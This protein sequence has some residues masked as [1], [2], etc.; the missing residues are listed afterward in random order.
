MSSSLSPAVV[1]FAAVLVVLA[2]VA[3]GSVTTGL[4]A[5]RENLD[6]AVG[7]SGVAPVET[8]AVELT[9]SGNPAWQDAIRVVHEGDDVA[10]VSIVTDTGGV[11]EF[12]VSRVVDSPATVM[13]RLDAL[14][15]VGMDIS[16]FQLLVDGQQSPYQSVDS[17]GYT[18]VSFHMASFS[19][20]AVGFATVPPAPDNET[21]GDS[22]DGTGSGD[23]GNSTVDD[24]SNDNGSIGDNSTVDDSSESN[25]SVDDNSTVDDS[26]NDNGSIGD[27]STVD[28]SS[29]DNGSI[30]DN[31]TV[32]DSSDDNVT[33]DGSSPADDGNST[34]DDSNS[35]GGTAGDAGDNST[36]DGGDTSV[37]DSGDDGT[38]GEPTRE[39]V[40]DA[41]DDGSVGDGTDDSSDDS[42][43]DDS[44]DGTGDGTADSSTDEPAQPAA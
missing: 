44:T 18:W 22:D 38:A 11:V 12:T 15:A 32:D 29:N 37:D 3:G 20:H 42:T 36:D 8:G 21:V 1:A 39:P 41:G 27:N 5:D 25:A 2:A 16:A 31:S 34:V 26:S 43:A 23:S 33:I 13:V 14:A 35:D 24:S 17:D 40:D 4:F 19:T 9:G 6:V 30:S 7:G 28:D 10:V